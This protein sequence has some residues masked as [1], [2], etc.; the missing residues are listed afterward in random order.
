MKKISKPC[1]LYLSTENSNQRHWNTYISL[2]S[3]E[4]KK[5]VN[6]APF[7]HKPLLFF[8]E[9]LVKF[10]ANNLLEINFDQIKISFDS[11][12]KPYFPDFP[13]LHFNVSHSNEI[14][15]LI[16]PHIFFNVKENKK[17]R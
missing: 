8:S 14:V 10:A 17:K 5:R 1:I 3:A 12:G 15:T 4:R 9:L 13:D 2:L 16:I 11:Q 7:N 6:N